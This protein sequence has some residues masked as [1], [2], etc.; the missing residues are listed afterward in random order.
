M[1]A[2]RTDP[3]IMHGAVCFAGTRV[4]VKSLFDYLRRGR[5]IDVF[6]EHFPTVERW[7]VD[8]VLRVSAERL[9][10]GAA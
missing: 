8:A 3:E 10:A 6:L 1:E 5:T 2:T 4:Q 9:V 7:Q